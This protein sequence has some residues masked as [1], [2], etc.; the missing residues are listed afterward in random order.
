M[1]E[2]QILENLTAAPAVKK[3]VI[4]A[5]LIA[6]KRKAGQFV[7]V[8]P[9]ERGERI[10]LTIADSDVE[11]G[12][13]TLFVQEV[14]K[15]TRVLG[16]LPMG[17]SLPDV[18]GPLGEPT[19]IKNY[20]RVVC[21]AGGVGVAEIYPVAAA[22]KAA[23]N[24]M[25]TIIGARS[26]NYIILKDELKAISDRLMITTDDGSFGVPGFVTDGLKQ[27][28]T[29]GETFDQAFCIGPVPMMRAVCALTKTRNLPTTVSLNPIMID[30]TGMCGG[31]RVTVGGEVKFACVDGPDFDGHLVDFDELVR[32]QQMYRQEE[33]Q[34]A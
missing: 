29:A 13:I 8:R 4:H 22:L 7:I 10:P 21:L 32:R 14:G 6:R 23:G 26:Q 34:S 17:Y 2:N 12:S 3:L 30:G 28:F 9:N 5:P 25:T 1:N 31:C 33:T 18:V 24:R 27:F 20:G 15:T 11:R 16:S 19:H